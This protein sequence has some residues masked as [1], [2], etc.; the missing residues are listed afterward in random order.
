MEN[1][2]SEKSELVEVTG[3][4]PIEVRIYQ[5]ARQWDDLIPTPTDGVRHCNACNQMVH[6]IQDAEGLTLAIAA[7]QCVRV[8]RRAGGHYIGELRVP[9]EPSPT[10]L[11]WGD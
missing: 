1:L 10:K 6:Q 5:C 2:K 11:T 3:G 8:A 9:Y 7:K 4:F